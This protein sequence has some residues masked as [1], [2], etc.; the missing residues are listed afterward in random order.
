M[1]MQGG[2]RTPGA[3]FTL[4]GPRA[5]LKVWARPHYSG[6]GRGCGGTRGVPR[7]PGLSW[8]QLE[9]PGGCCVL[10]FVG[11]RGSREQQST[12]ETLLSLGWVHPPCAWSI[13]AGLFGPFLPC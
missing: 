8:H 3:S 13:L 1:P 9:E 5:L 7:V 6:L 12:L 10:C 4:R 11:A 2:H